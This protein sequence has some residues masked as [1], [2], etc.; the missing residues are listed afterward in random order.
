MRVK[1]V[2]RA[3]KVVVDQGSWKDGKM[4]NTAFP[5]G[6]SPLHI[7]AKF[8]WRSLIFEA[9]D[10]RFRVLIV[11]R[12]D[13]QKYSAF[14]GRVEGKDM[15]MLARYEWHANE[16]GWHVHVP[17]TCDD[18]E[19]LPGRTGG[20]DRRVPRA[21][22]QHRSTSFDVVDDESAFRRAYDAFRLA[23]APGNFVLEA[24]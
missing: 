6:K 15:L 16:P 5:L 23:S 24:Q 12:L 17:R 22:G 13:L 4:P 10:F 2:V 18:R 20:C 14:L 21:F 8:R 7:S 9:L 3:S 11:Y 1:D 19:Q